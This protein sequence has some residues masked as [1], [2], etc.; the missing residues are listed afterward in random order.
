MRGTARPGRLTDMRRRYWA[1]LVVNALNGSTLLGLLAA[2]VGRTRLTRGPHGL[3]LGWGYRFPVP[4]RR[5]PAF[6]LG[7][8]ILLRTND[9]RFL[10]RRPTL[11]IHEA[12]HATQYA[13]CLGVVMVAL[14]LPAAAWSWLCTGD[15]ASRNVFER[16]AGLADGGYRERPLR[17]VFA[18]ITGRSAG[19]QTEV[20]STTAAA[21]GD[22]GATAPTPR[23][24]PAPYVTPAGTDHMPD[25]GAGTSPGTS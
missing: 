6:T 8:V 13:Y 1:R 24:E 7:N 14:Y 22:P 10:Q 12:R 3:L 19:R 18:K 20:A 16:L 17:P 25:T 21:V 5:A 4:P 2:A 23:G 11:L 15:P 9:P